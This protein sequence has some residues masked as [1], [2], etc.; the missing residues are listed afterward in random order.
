MA[1]GG[2]AGAANANLGGADGIAGSG[3]GALG[4]SSGS[5][6]APDSAC[7]EHPTPQRTQGTALSLSIEPVLAAKPF[8]FGAPNA[9]PDG[10]SVVPSNFRFYVSAVQ[11][12]RSSGDPVAV[13][14]VTAAGEPE[15]YGVHLFTADDDDT[16]KLRV[17]APAGEYTG[18]SFALGIKLACNK[19]FPGD[20]AEPL[21]VTSQMTWPAAG[22]LYLRYE[23]LNTP[24]E[25]SASTGKVPPAV[26]M[27][28]SVVTELVPRVTV[29]GPLSVP[30]SGT[31]VKSLQLSMDEIF[32]GA[33]ADIDVSKTEGLDPGLLSED[34]V[35]A[36]ERLR[37]E[38]PKRPVF[39]FGP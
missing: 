19:P 33:T 17:L 37:Q 15:P 12:L 23:A 29:S 9:L 7:A 32:A 21:T 25:G 16:T 31:L 18:V 11:L 13:D 35:V 5:S 3:A 27:G 1:A 20:M 34:A 38:L 8:V 28:G 6:A 24:A 30:A 2:S 4:G 22:Y 26:H 14:L 39:S 10:G 36:G